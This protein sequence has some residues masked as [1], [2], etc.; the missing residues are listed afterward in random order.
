MDTNPPIRTCDI[1]YLR[2]H[3]GLDENMRG[4]YVRKI[5][6]ETCGGTHKVESR[7]PR[8]K[9][10]QADCGHIHFSI[11]SVI[12]LL[13]TTL[14]TSRLVWAAGTACFGV[15]ALTG[16]ANLR[17]VGFANLGVT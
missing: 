5:W 10:S 1:I 4:K 8:A 17:V 16:S 15:D 12:K 2:C 7:H 6:G 14:V 9:P 11:L 13:S 3:V